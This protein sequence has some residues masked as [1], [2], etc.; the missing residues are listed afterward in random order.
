MSFQ[1]PLKIIKEKVYLPEQ[2]FNADEIALFWKKK[3]KRVI[4]EALAKN[5][6]KQQDLR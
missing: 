2:V 3:K 1:T 5:K 6:S 4:E